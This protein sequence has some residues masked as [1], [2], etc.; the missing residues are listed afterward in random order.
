MQRNTTIEQTENNSLRT[1][2]LVIGVIL[3]AANLRAPFTSI[4]SL[5][6]FIRT[7]LEIS[8]ALAGTIT[9]LPLLAFAVLSP[10]APR[11]ARRMSMEYTLFLSLVLLAVAINLRS[12]FGTGALFLGTLFIGMAI[13][14]GNV[15]LPGF[16]KMKFPSKVGVMTGIYAVFMN[17]FAAL[18]SGVSVPLS[19]I[20][21]LGWKWSLAFWS[22]PA[23]LAIIIWIP[24]LKEGKNSAHVNDEANSQNKSNLLC[25]PLAWCITLFMGL[26]SLIFY[27][28]VTWLP[29]I[30][31]GVGY[32]TSAAGWMLFLMQFA[33]IPVTFIIPIIAERM[34]NQKGLSGMTALFFIIGISGLFIGNPFI[35]PISVILIGVAGGTA[36]SLSMMF[37]SMRTSS[38]VEASEMSGMAQSFGYLLA[39]T[40][41]LLF[42]ALHD[43]TTSWT[44][45]LI[46]LLVVSVIILFVGI[47]AGKKKVINESITDKP[48]TIGIS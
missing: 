2:L 28:L 10:F 21:H 48:Q 29:E 43:L 32:S 46:M 15:L 13:A 8:H 36:F 24:Q 23:L 38:A 3:I 45:P 12:L 31:Q 4:G 14:F 47:E 42:G 11:I 40:G 34:D 7:D 39:A 1:W 22:V 44:V 35:I 17:I 18:A 5:I 41:P 33:I 30:L 6:P 20:G 37:F 27:T 19:S 9:T 25:S 26:Q 16:V